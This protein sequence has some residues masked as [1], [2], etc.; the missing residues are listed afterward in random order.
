MSLEEKSQQ[1]KDIISTYD[2][3]WFLGDLSG[4][5]KAISNGHAQDQLGKLSSPLR[6][7]YFLGGL[8]VTS[9]SSNGIDFQYSPEKW[10]QIVIL[11]NE[12]ER[13]YDKLFFPKPDEEIDDEW[14]KI[15]KVA[16]P[17][18]LAYF[19]QGPLN[20]EEQAINWVRDLYS[21]LDDIIKL[22]H[23]LKTD[24]FLKFYENIDA[25]VQK[26]FQGYSSPKGEFKKEWLEYTKIK[27][28][29]VDEAQNLLKQ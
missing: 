9:D 4:L 6:Q 12:I 3:Q 28:G 16:M 21:Q 22:E 5:M 13:E 11:L 10:N 7:L 1:L 25:L 27:M 19:N 23:G 26:K 15:R 29:L 14:K 8:L 2:T 20:Y 24:D 18:F 17:S